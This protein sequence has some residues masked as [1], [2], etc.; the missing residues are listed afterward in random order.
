MKLSNPVYDV[1]KW[2]CLVGLPAV[3]VCYVALSGIWDLPYAEQISMT[4]NAICTL[5]GA[6][7]GVSTAEYNKG[8]HER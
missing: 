3:A 8:Q 1:L 5:I 7:I 2:V 6:L 4:V